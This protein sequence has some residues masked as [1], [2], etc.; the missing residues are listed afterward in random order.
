MITLARIDSLHL[1]TERERTDAHG[2]RPACLSRQTWGSRAFRADG[3]WGLNMQ[4]MRV[5]IRARPRA[6]EPPRASDNGLCLK[7]PSGR[8]ATARK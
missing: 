1:A 4:R 8:I 7:L 3:D 2:S 5:L 6:G